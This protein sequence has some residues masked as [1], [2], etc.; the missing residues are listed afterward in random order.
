[1]FLTVII[2]NN[3]KY[4][5]S[6]GLVNGK[7]INR[8]RHNQEELPCPGSCL[9]VVILFHIPVPFA[10]SLS[11]K[12]RSHVVTCRHNMMSSSGFYFLNKNNNNFENSLLK[13]E[14]F[15]TILKSFTASIKSY[16]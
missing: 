10:Y 16:L 1:M 3:N 2:G 8:V 4:D 7:D 15:K 9:Y 6:C 5:E 14:T 12:Y 13:Y 11:P